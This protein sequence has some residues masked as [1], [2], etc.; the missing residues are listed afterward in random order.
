MI[1]VFSTTKGAT[2]VCANRLAQE[3][4]L[5]VNAPVAE[6]WPEF[7]Q[8]GK[9]N[10]PVDYLLS[11]R[12]RA[13]VGRRE[14]H[15]R[16]RARVGPDDPRA[17]APGTRLGAGHRARLSR[18]HVRLPRRRG[19]AARH[20]SQRRHVLPRGDR[21]ATRP[22]LLHR[23]PG[24]ARRPRSRR[25]SAASTDSS[26]A[27][28]A[29]RTPTRRPWPRSR[30]SSGPSRCSGKALSGGGAFGASGDLQHPCGARGRDPGGRR[31]HR[32]RVPSPGCTRPASARS[33]GSAC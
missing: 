13:R 12:G 1:I 31:H 22:R 27:V 21:R 19:G 25:S 33:T 18:G 30:R 23:S 26:V 14:A 9:E 20:R 28:T 24:G 10:I 16:G 4:R 3:G 11:H 2:A 32:R 8:A 17:R 7:A 29:T 15:A 6:Y 5:D